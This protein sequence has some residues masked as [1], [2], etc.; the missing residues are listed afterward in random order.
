MVVLDKKDENLI[1]SFR[2][3]PKV[4]YLLVDYLN[5]YDL[6]HHDKIVFLESALKSINK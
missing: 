5:P 6:M 1:K 3:L 2:N 4:K